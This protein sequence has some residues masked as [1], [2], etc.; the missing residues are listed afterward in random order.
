MIKI[1]E[2]ETKKL[3][4]LTS[5][6]VSFDYKP[7]IVDE[8]KLLR[9]QTAVEYHSTEK[10]WEIPITSLQDILD[11]LCT[12]DNITVILQEYHEEQSIP[13]LHKLSYKTQPFDY[14][15]DGINF[16]LSHSKWL[17]L[18]APGLGKTLQLT[19][20]AQELK[21]QR[22]LQHCLVICGI[23]TLKTNWKT[24][25]EK[26]SDLTCRILG[27]RINKKG[28]LVVDGID[29]RLEQLKNPIDEFFVITNIE[30]LRNEKI[31]SALLDTRVNKFD[32]IVVDEI[33]KARSHTSQQGKGLHKLKSKYQVGATGTLLLN[34]PLDCYSALKWI[35]VEKSNM[36]NF[37]AFYCI[38]GG[39]TG[40]EITGYKNLEVLQ[41]QIK[42]YSLR[43][44]KDILNLPERTIITEYVD[45]SSAQEKFYK[46]IE[47]GVVEE[48]DKVI[49]KTS[50]LLSMVGR[51]RQATV[52]PSILTTENI[53]SAKI[54]R[55][56][57]LTEQIVSNGEKVVLFS[58]FKAPVYELSKRL[59]D[60]PHVI[61]T[62]DQND[63]EID[64]AKE[65]F[66]TNPNVKVFIGTWQKAGTGLTLNAASYMIHLDTAWTDG[67]FQQTCDRIHRIGTT[68]PVF[69][70][71]LV[72]KN[73]IDERVL[74]LIQDKAAIS[75]YVIDEKISPQAIDSLRKYIE[76]L[77]FTVN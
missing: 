39:V 13:D 33:H 34:S 16:G 47:A 49:I 19:E 71:N 52:L 21:E 22:G 8:L 5:L 4:G 36:S 68:N 26:H 7:E 43:R 77:K 37:K 42:L 59:K 27:Q 56:V 17:L 38:F 75:D 60:I 58:A 53:E 40:K 35:D 3:P 63:F 10:E 44:T 20:L 23:N 48:A 66:Q 64:K 14:Q 61:V 51:L 62:G 46:N 18:D 72:T 74:E 69:I 73:T 11:R 29:K 31:V 6:F 50:N 9:A 70:Y 15:L 55:A 1:Q 65:E 24:E 67:D 57:D 32:M 28:Q 30:T 41:E 25:I 12:K 54:E 2:R 45:M 76:E